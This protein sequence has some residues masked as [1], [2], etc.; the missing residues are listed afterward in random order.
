MATPYSKCPTCGKEFK[1]N[2][3]PHMHKVHCDKKHGILAEPSP[4]VLIDPYKN[5]KAK[6]GK[7]YDKES[8]QHCLEVIKLNLNKYFVIEQMSGN[9]RAMINR[10]LQESDAVIE[11]ALIELLKIHGIKA[12]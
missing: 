1:F 4:A 11:K 12:Y 10:M 2:S 6:G 5:S 7:K 9:E 8:L 3:V